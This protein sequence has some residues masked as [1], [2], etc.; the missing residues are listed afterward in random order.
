VTVLHLLAHEP[1]V[2]RRSSIGDARD[3]LAG[4]LRV[5]DPRADNSLDAARQV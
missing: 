3:E 5:Q 2:A 4:Q 1:R